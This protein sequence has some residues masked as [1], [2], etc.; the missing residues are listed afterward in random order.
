MSFL[1]YVTW[2]S[3]NFL[4]SFPIIQT[5]VRA[6]KLHISFLS[7]HILLNECINLQFH[8]LSTLSSNSFSY[9]FQSFNYSS[10]KILIILTSISDKL[11]TTTYSNKW[12]A[13]VD[14]FPESLP[15]TGIV[16][17]FVHSRCCAMPYFEFDCETKS[18]FEWA[19]GLFVIW[20]KI[21]LVL[22]MKKES[23]V[24]CRAHDSRHYLRETCVQNFR[25]VTCRCCSVVS[26]NSSVVSVHIAATLS[27]DPRPK[28]H[29]WPSKCSSPNQS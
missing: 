23:K 11:R 20:D 21:V 7:R 9:Q 22:V 4:H 17:A 25:A 1:Y 15:L 3:Y 24:H 26:A 19:W 28:D 2:E 10:Y 27:C 5:I 16:S 29:Q 8:F 14:L 13:K 18:L 12:I 6:V